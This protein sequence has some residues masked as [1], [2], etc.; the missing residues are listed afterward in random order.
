MTQRALWT[1]SEAPGV[2]QLPWNESL[3]G[4]GTVFPVGMTREQFYAFVYRCKNFKLTECDGTL[5]WEDE[6]VAD[7]DA[8]GFSH[9]L[10]Y[11]LANDVAPIDYS[12]PDDPET[13][14]GDFSFGSKRWDSSW[15]EIEPDPATTLADT[16][17]PVP[18]QTAPY[19]A[20]APWEPWFVSLPQFPSEFGP[21][22]SLFPLSVRA[23]G[24]RVPW[25][26]PS[27]DPV[28][29]T[30]N[31][32]LYTLTEIP[33]WDPDNPG[34]Y[35][36][37]GVWQLSSD[38]SF[39]VSPEGLFYPHLDIFILPV[40]AP[41]FP[42]EGF[43]SRD[44]DEKGDPVADLILSFAGFSLNVPV[45]LT[46]EATSAAGVSLAITAC[47]YWAHNPGDGGGPWIDATTGESLRT[48]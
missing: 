1:S 33:E 30:F 8:D 37:G 5:F 9:E 16:W 41:P 44:I 46:G 23:G 28:S 13:T 48:S 19:Y 40:S 38:L 6:G 34:V 35:R 39:R 12:D 36:N 18:G 14:E 31:I 3:A 27:S 26:E 22:T 4:P 29:T 20:S 7:P 47:E 17:L 11:S 2:V 10:E 42:D 21:A 43:R 25:V 45:F 15:I 24:G 32:P